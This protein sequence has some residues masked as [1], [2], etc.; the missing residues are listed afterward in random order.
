VTVL[1]R[2]G[3]TDCPAPPNRPKRPERDADHCKA[4]SRNP[5]HNASRNTGRRCSRCRVGIACTCPAWM[6]A[7]RRRSRC[8]PPADG[9]VPSTQI[10][11]PA[12]RALDRNADDQRPASRECGAR[13]NHHNRRVFPA[14]KRVHIR[15]VRHRRFSST[16]SSPA[17]RRRRGVIP[18]GHDR[19]QQ[20]IQPTRVRQRRHIT[21][22]C[23]SRGPT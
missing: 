21:P 13:T 7:A 23:R 6:P 8:S 22:T 4:A 15:D 18:V 14:G 1:A 19:P 10:A 20:P 11:I 2:R 5:G 16:G 17:R 9:L 12:H 3:R